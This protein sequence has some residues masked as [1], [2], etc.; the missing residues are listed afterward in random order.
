MADPTEDPK[1]T[2]APAAA[3]P[4]A[5]AETAAQAESS[6]TAK[7]ARGFGLFRS[8]SFR[9]PGEALHPASSPPPPPAPKKRR[10]RT[11]TLSIISGFLSFLLIACLGAAIGL[12]S[13][14]Q[15]IR[16][17][18]PLSEDKVLYFPPRT[19]VPDILAQLEREGVID[20]P[21]LMNVSLWL[22]GNRG[23]V[24]AGEYL[25]K[26]EA[27]LRDV[28]DLLVSGR[29]VL[30]SITIPEGLTSEQIVQRLR[31]SD[32]LAGD[33]REAP[34]EG[35][36]L[37]ET[38]RVA[39][40]M[41]RS[42][43]IRKMQEDQRKLVEQVWAKR[44]PSLPLRTPYEMVTL[45]SIVEK[46][47]GKAEERPRVAGVFVNR[48]QKRMKLQSDPTIVYGIVGGK[49]TL[50]RGI[51][52]DEISRPSAYNT[53]VIEGLPPGPIANPGRA[54]LEAVANPMKTKDLF[55]V[56]DGT[57]GH[58]FAETLDEHSRNVSRWRALE[59][60]KAGASN[61]DRAP[62]VV[63]GD[64]GVPNVT[65]P[66]VAPPRG[67]RGALEL[68]GPGHALVD[69]LPR[70]AGFDLTGTFGLK[71]LVAS[72]MAPAT[73]L[74]RQIAENRKLAAKKGGGDFANF[75]F[76]SGAERVAIRG[77]TDRPQLDGDESDFDMGRV[78]GGNAELYPVS[79]KR[80]ADQ[81]AR[82]AKYGIDAGPGEPSGLPPEALALQAFPPR[83]PRIAIP[84]FDASEG[85][86]LDPLKDKKWD[87]S[88]PKN[89][90][91]ALRNATTTLQ[92]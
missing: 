76:E 25:F 79:P 87:L 47:T 19:D 20:S 45:A 46:E 29:Q 78:E 11:G 12:S 35:L 83:Q 31:E 21:L 61:V 15:K 43:L 81:Q 22:E 44:D 27:S 80:L 36:I 40:G 41:S 8:Q 60:E 53:Y 73:V 82:A 30:H 5:A 24:K 71:G 17:A 57:G 84:I 23:N 4:A 48:L 74:A 66:S 32:V 34:K 14:Q 67:Q 50:G 92:N 89:I 3:E 38:Y 26:R 64:P 54:A 69:A 77:L 86:A 90:P 10:R 42:D 7:P 58:V 91:S 65:P 49:G 70:M 16:S 59:R 39:R 75:T 63:P 33:L 37:P 52:R 9:S 62:A 18:G 72:G 28:I 6:A 13:A 1:P 56:A 88:S 55:F 68:P 51:T 2:E 85:T